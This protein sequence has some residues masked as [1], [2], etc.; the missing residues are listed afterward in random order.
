MPHTTWQLA[1]GRTLDLTEPRIVAILNITP[2]SFSD[3]GDYNTLALAIERAKRC[4]AEGA[5]VLEV[6][7]ESTRPGAERIAVEEQLERVLP[8]I[9]G[10]REALPGIPISVDTTRSAVARHAVEAGAHIINDVSAGEE[11]D[12][13]LALAAE[14]G[15]GLVLMHRLRPPGE[16]SFSDRYAGEP[17]YADVVLDVRTYLEDRLRL[18]M[19]AGVREDAVVLDPG[20]G[21][22][23]SVEQNL[24][25]IRRTPE[26]CSI[27]RAVMSAASRKSFVGRVGLG[28]DSE[29]SERLGG[30]VAVTVLHALAGAKL[31]RV[32][33]VSAHAQALRWVAAIRGNRLPE[34]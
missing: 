29:P 28:R 2:D 7:G 8:V 12:A 3:G 9:E 34:I 10:I 17:E 16:D 24:D 30:S 19:N 27:G 26:L 1:H 33:D 11:D 6:G 15:A 25:L 32:H 14:T 31:F 21:F 23:K 4:V 22:G 20:L 18:A 13:M 5:D